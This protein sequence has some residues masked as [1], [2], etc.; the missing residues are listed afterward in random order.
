VPI[1]TPLVTMST[2]L[3]SRYC[4]KLSGEA[5]DW[6]A[7][8]PHSDARDGGFPTAEELAALGVGAGDSVEV[9]AADGAVEI[10][11][12]NPFV[13]MTHKERMALLDRFGTRALE[14][15]KPDI[16]WSFRV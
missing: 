15:P 12:V 9:T 13:G 6:E 8:F 3:T 10:R 5:Q 4:S 16:V 7:A 1:G 14:P 2:P 11:S